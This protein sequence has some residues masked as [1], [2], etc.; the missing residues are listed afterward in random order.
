L[1]PAPEQASQYLT[2]LRTEINAA[3]IVFSIIS[4][5]QAYRV[6]QPPKHLS[7]RPPNDRHYP[8]Y[9]AAERSVTPH[10]EL[11]PIVCPRCIESASSPIPFP[12][13]K[14]VRGFRASA[15][16]CRDRPASLSRETRPL[17]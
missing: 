16:K 12:A 13:K 6:S 9:L 7:Q 11:R 15:L 17:L 5:S 10:G 2:I 8:S 3:W 1:A 14:N 4:V